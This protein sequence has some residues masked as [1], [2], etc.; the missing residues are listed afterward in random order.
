[1]RIA[2]LAI[3]ESI[4]VTTIGTLDLLSFANAMYSPAGAPVYEIKC[5]GRGPELQFVGGARISCDHTFADPGQYDVVLVPGLLYTGLAETV[6]SYSD[7]IA[8]LRHQIEGGATVGSMCVGAFLVAATGYLNGKRTTL[9]WAYADL[10]R[11]MYPAVQVDTDPL[12]VD[13][14]SL[15]S[16]GGA[17]SYLN[18]LL[19][20]VDRTMGRDA[21]LNLAQM[22]LIDPDKVSQS[23]YSIF[24]SYKQHGDEAVR[25]AQE[26]LEQAY[27]AEPSVEVLAEAAAIS[28]RHFVR[29]FKTA[30]GLTPTA[31]LQKVRIEAARNALISTDSRVN[32]IQLAV[33][34][35]DEKTFRMMFRRHTGL[36]PT[37][38]R[39]KFRTQ[40]L[41][42]PRL[43]AS[44]KLAL[45]SQS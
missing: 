5:V 30:T 32:E 35:D 6:H 38:Y 9:H 25:T 31:Y 10:F 41:Q 2:V 33:G 36:S 1:M 15:F 27:Q 42:F 4:P 28:P 24:L 14:G 26:K 18:L 7:A 17:T 44:N 37:E 43:M 34:Y 20:F 16:G 13:N 29:R 39:N 21:M 40:A 8:W 19:Y 12:V 23:Q 22:L 3:P 45:V 11:Q